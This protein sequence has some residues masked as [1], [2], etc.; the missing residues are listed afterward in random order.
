MLRLRIQTK[1]V[2][3]VDSKFLNFLLVLA[4][5][6]FMGLAPLRAQN[7][8]TSDANGEAITAP[9]Q[10]S[11][12]G[13]SALSPASTP[14]A[15]VNASVKSDPSAVPRDT[16][17]LASRFTIGWIGLFGLIGLVGLLGLL[18]DR[19]EQP[20]SGRPELVVTRQRSEYRRAA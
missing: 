19:K 17:S 9:A 20:R 13:H 12:A 6:A 14:D 18:R 10:H 1:Q 5:F 3:I 7:P 2:V 15:N 11:D 8:N 4:C 16:D